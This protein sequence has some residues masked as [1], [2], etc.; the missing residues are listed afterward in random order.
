MKDESPFAEIII[1]DGEPWWNH[2]PGW[3]LDPD[4]CMVTP[5]MVRRT[6]TGKGTTF[7]QMLHGLSET[8]FNGITERFGEP[9]A[10][11]LHHEHANQVTWAVWLWKDGM[12]RLQ[13]DVG[14]RMIECASFNR[15][16]IDWINDKMRP[17][18]A[19]EKSYNAIPTRLPWR[20]L[21]GRSSLTSGSP[22]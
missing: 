8:C 4:E 2:A 17:L 21:S 22:P 1:P 12:L 20:T 13:G 5:A 7:F 6:K 9:A 16:D 10:V 19:S 15:E 3:H 14:R 11:R 18:A